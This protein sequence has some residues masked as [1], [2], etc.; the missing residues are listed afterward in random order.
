MKKY[1]VALAVMLISIG[2]ISAVSA[3]PYVPPD[4]PT[5]PTDGTTCI[6]CWQNSIVQ[7]D[8]QKVQDVEICPNSPLIFNEG[9][10]AAVTVTP[11]TP[12]QVTTDGRYVKVGFSK[13][14]QGMRQEIGKLINPGGMTANK[15]MQASWVENQGAKEYNPDTAA[16][17]Y[18]GAYIRQKTFQLVYNVDYGYSQNPNYVAIFNADN[19]L[20]VLSDNLNTL[21]KTVGVS[22]T[23]SDS[24]SSTGRYSNNVDIDANIY[25]HVN[26]MG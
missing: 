3:V 20:A 7:K 6:D 11:E 25:S 18:E 13:V 17:D 14:E 22:S 2:F 12:F 9:M 15:A 10:T 23:A 21:S 16:W 4:V 8:I 1:L 24:A 19:K 26:A 5:P